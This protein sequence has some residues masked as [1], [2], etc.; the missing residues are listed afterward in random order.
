LKVLISGII[1]GLIIYFSKVSSE[2]N[3]MIDKI[4]KLS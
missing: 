4:L 3:K 2:I 1:Y